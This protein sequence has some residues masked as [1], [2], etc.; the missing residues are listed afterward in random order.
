MTAAASSAPLAA[1]AQATAPDSAAS[2]TRLG[3]DTLAVERFVRTPQ[4]V[5]DDH[6]NHVAPDGSMRRFESRTF[7]PGKPGSEPIR[8]QMIARQGDSLRNEAKGG[9]GEGVR[10]VAAPP[11]TRDRDSVRR[12]SGIGTR[13]REL[14]G[15]AI[16]FH[17]PRSRVPI[18][19]SLRSRLPQY[20]SRLHRRRSPGRDRTPD[21]RDSD[22]QHHGTE[23]GH[24]IGRTDPVE[25]RS[26]ES[27]RS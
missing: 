11:T 2:V 4:R 1:S 3:T 15:E 16:H 10:S 24:R 7:D 6:G 8:T 13:I 26:N 19:D 14:E 18:P 5:E 20:L 21:R 12:A 22:E 9:R 23:N 27:R 17:S 25:L